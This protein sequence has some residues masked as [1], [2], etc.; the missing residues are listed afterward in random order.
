MVVK[1]IIRKQ[2]YRDSVVLLEISKKIQT[3]PGILDAV[4][5]MGTSSNKE[6]LSNLEMLTEEVS[7]ASANDLIIVI[8][9]Y[10]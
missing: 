7:A 8:K 9:S 1:V 3:S 2:E 6:I 4:V 5:V 10:F